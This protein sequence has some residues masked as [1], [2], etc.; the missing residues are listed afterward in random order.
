MSCLFD[1]IKIEGFIGLYG[2]EQWWLK[3]LSESERAEILSTLQLMGGDSA[4][5]LSGKILTDQKCSDFLATLAGWFK[6]S[7]RDLGYKILQKAE[8]NLDSYSTV[9]EQHFTYNA[10]I[11]FYYRDRDKSQRYLDKALESCRKQIS[12]SKAAIREFKKQDANFLPSHKGFHQLAIY[13][14]KQKNHKEAL[15]LAKQAQA[16]GW[17]GDWGKR[18]ERLSKKL[19]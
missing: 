11:E 16:D 19:A 3:E 1:K 2:L 14:E 8:D 5:L 17:R 7:N 4:S 15:N 13:E 18:I 12:I 9:L 10:L 6:V